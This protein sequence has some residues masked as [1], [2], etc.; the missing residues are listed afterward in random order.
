MRTSSLDMREDKHKEDQDSRQLK[1]QVEDANKA[2]K[3]LAMELSDL[4]KLVSEVLVMPGNASFCSLL[5]NWISS[6]K[7]P[8]EFSPKSCLAIVTECLEMNKANDLIS[9][10]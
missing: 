6:T 10:S 1:L 8:N 2:I 9:I 5:G 7:K 3:T 4:Q